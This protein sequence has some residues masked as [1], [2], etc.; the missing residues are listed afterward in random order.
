MPVS[1]DDLERRLRE[2]QPAVRLVSEIALSRVL[3]RRIEAGDRVPNNPLL[4][5]WVTAESIADLEIDRGLPRLLLMTTPD[6]RLLHRYSDDVVLA[7][8]NRLL[9]R[10]DFQDR[11][12]EGAIPFGTL[13]EA[14]RREIRHVLES[15]RL[16][17]ENPTDEEVGRTFRAVEAELHVNRPDA[18]GD[19]FPLLTASVRIAHESLSG[20]HRDAHRPSDVSV[21]PA[22]IRPDVSG[23]VATGKNHVRT[24]IN[25]HRRP[26]DRA[27]AA[28]ILREGLGGRLRAALHWDAEHLTTWQA[29]LTALLPHTASA[30]WTPAAK[31]L[32]ELQKLALDLAQP[33]SAVA[34]FEWLR[35]F[36][37]KSVRQPLDK[38]RDIILLRHLAK[39]DKQ[40][41]RV[42]LDEP[43]RHAW[44]DLIGRE[45]AAAEARIRAILSP[46]LRDALDR[47]GLAPANRVESVARE[48]L[49][50]EL[51][52][53]VCDRGFFRLA[54][55]RDAIARNQVKLHDLDGFRELASGDELLRADKIL[56]EELFGIYQRGEIYLRGIQRLSAA[57]FGTKIG[58]WITLFV[59]LPFGGAFLSLE[60]LQHLLHGAGG[61]ANA[62]G[63]HSDLHHA[64][65]VSWWSVLALGGFFLGL[66]HSPPFRSAVGAGFRRV[67]SWLTTVFVTLPRAAW[68]SRAARIL[69]RNRVG[70]FLWRTVALPLALGAITAVAIVAYTEPESFAPAY[71]I[72]IGALVFVASIVAIHSPP[73][74]RLYDALSEAALD[75]GRYVW[76][77]LIPGL[78]SWFVW[79]FREIADAV[80]RLLYTADEW[81]RFREGQSRETL[82][83]KVAVAVVWFPIAYVTRFVF[84]LLVEPQVNPVKHFPVVTV[85]HK[86]IWPMVPQL[87]RLTGLS[88]WTMGTI[89]N[90]VPGIFGF[91]AWELKENWRLYA[92]N[93]PERLR[94]VPIGH[95]GETMRGLLRPGFHAGTVP[96]LYRKLRALRDAPTLDGK[97]LHHLHHELHHVADA[98]RR[99]VEWELLPLLNDPA[100]SVG[101]VTV[102]CRRIEATLTK[103]EGRFV[104]AWELIDGEIAGSESTGNWTP[105]ADEYAAVAGM[106][107]LAAVTNPE[108]PRWTDWVKRWEPR[109]T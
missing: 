22:A 61:L 94:P 53:A 1:S 33:L 65:I 102:G 4:P 26:E 100:V 37:R 27:T 98:V 11:P 86:I 55:L 16:L 52:R 109:A 58:R 5:L 108:P 35:S 82:W 46:I 74:L 104:L 92:A 101:D 23:I 44:D 106:N 18:I 69:V 48:K 31:A 64:H 43:A 57:G 13:P 12:N 24:A 9:D 20:N 3:A 34:P 47:A 87:S 71:A 39:V 91:I 8:Y 77:S 40:L 15:E 14:I 29:A 95:H 76:A 93:R 49:V 103:G 56:G 70:S 97:K 59:L 83:L 84:Y 78:V 10:V 51:V 45:R 6:D 19:F 90:A 32:Y 89:V 79:I 62:L 42:P 85:S 28:A 72:G 54:D 99:Q 50:A 41:A 63:L 75:T 107:A 36:G 60:F 73:G 96:K 30:A 67:G 21:D 2:R 66:L 7:V 38:A 105:T 68:R 88:P 81:L 25:Y 80:E 17:P